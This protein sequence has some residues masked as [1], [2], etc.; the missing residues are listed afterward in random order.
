MCISCPS[1]RREFHILLPW[2]C[3]FEGIF[4]DFPMAMT[5]PIKPNTI[6]HW[7]QWQHSVLPLLHSLVKRK[8]GKTRPG[9]RWRNANLIYALQ[10]TNTNP[11]APGA[12]K[13]PVINPG[14]WLQVIG[15]ITN[16]WEQHAGVRA[17]AGDAQG[18]QQGANVK[19]SFG[20]Q[21]AGGDK[22]PLSVLMNKDNCSPVNHTELQFFL[23]YT[24]AKDVIKLSSLF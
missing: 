22:K 13:S 10:C 23:N 21:A 11:A 16:T 2:Q 4:M 24:T 17:G 12:V 15:N 14:S 5:A 19:S 18:R 9:K 3:E 1:S 6:K 7:Q 8:R 20:S